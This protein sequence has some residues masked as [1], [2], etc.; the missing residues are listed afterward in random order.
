MNDISEQVRRLGLAPTP[1]SARVCME[2]QRV[3]V[4]KREQLLE[5]LDSEQIALLSYVIGEAHAARQGAAELVHELGRALRVHLEAPGLRT[6]PQ[7]ARRAK[8]P[9]LSSGARK[10]PRAAGGKRK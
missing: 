10:R 7:K 2:L 5:V 4:H 1:L 6:T 9:P 3:L 8:G